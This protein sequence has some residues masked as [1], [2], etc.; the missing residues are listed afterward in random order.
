MVGPVTRGVWNSTIAGL[1]EVGRTTLLAH[2]KLAGSQV[3]LMRK[4]T[5]L[6]RTGEFT[7]LSSLAFN[8]ICGVLLLYTI[9]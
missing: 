9:K 6:P 4:I 7:Y 2:F 3:A 5:V 1:A 8:L